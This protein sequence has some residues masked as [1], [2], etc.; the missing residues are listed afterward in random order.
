[1]SY[2]PPKE[3]L[4]AYARVLV[5][6]G[7]GGGNGIKPGDVVLVQVPEAA[8]PLFAPLRDVVLQAGGNPLMQFLPD[9]VDVARV[10]DIATPEQLAFFPATYYRGLVD[11][12]DHR[13]SIIAEADKY[14]FSRV[15]ASK[16]MAMANA[17]KPYREW[18]NVAEAAGRYT[19]T[20]GMYGTPA[21]AADVG[22][23]EEEYW[24]EIIQ[25]CYLDKADPIAVWR[26][27]QIE[28]QRIC[29]KLD[30]LEIVSLHVEGE[31]IDLT[32]GLGAGRRWLA[33]GG[34]NIPSFEVFI[35]PDWRKTSG[36]IRFNQPL[37]RYGNKIEAVKLEFKDG[38]IVDASAKQGQ[39]LLRE[40]IASEHANRIGEF[41]L[42]DTRHSPITRRM[43][44]TL[45]DENMGGPE[46]N[47][48]LAVGN[49]Y[50]ESYPGD[51][52]T[53]K[54][55]DWEKLGYNR[56]PVHVDI[57]STEPRRVTA[58]VPNGKQRVI[59]EHG[60]FTI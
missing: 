38:L 59:Y 21:M 15:S 11:Q 55:E 57:V 50:Q 28:L 14:E 48:H 3:V 13:I 10:Y 35:S 16:I 54:E 24:Q 42:T 31:G 29:T 53:L 7:L 36:Y 52:S 18:L 12:I 19:W 4:A 32:V 43:A 39:E 5:G 30:G 25:A 26:D 33:G 2:V 1:M 45:F 58:T 6:F 22:M 56:S 17:Q 44:E 40:M 46:G 60:R 27:L 23:S 34:A 37:Y 8:K 51:A 41:S 49:A 20:L 47:T 9:G